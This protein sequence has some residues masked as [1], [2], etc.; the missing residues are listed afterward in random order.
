MQLKVTNSRNIRQ[1]LMLIIKKWGLKVN[2]EPEIKKKYKVYVNF[3]TTLNK[4]QR[5]A[6]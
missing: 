6:R 2:A 4:I 1:V 3:K 5:K